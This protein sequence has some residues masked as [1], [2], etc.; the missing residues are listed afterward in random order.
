MTDK[1]DQE[2]GRF[3]TNGLLPLAEQAKAKGVHF[4]E[5]EIAA[6]V[7][8]YYLKRRRAS[9]TKEDFETGGCAS[10]EEVESALRTLWK[11]DQAI[12]LNRLAPSIAKLARALRTV[13][14]EADDV[15]NFIYVMY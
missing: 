3:F 8:S 13:E 4:L 11:D 9:M 15:S 10:A 6:D 7:Q 1:L 2:I 14:K 5:S 12:G